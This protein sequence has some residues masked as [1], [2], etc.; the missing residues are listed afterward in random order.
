[1]LDDDDDEE[2]EDNALN[3]VNILKKNLKRKKNRKKT[4]PQHLNKIN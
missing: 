3:S 1:M 4:L 2:E